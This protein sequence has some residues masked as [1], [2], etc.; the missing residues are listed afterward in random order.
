MV[1]SLFVS[2]IGIVI[3]VGSFA[4]FLLQVVAPLYW[5]LSERKR[6]TFSS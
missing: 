3:V 2:S 4:I 5:L 1:T 6:H